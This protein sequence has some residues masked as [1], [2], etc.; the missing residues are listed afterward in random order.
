MWAVQYI[1]SPIHKFQK[2]LKPDF[3]PLPIRKSIHTR[4]A[5][6]DEL[7]QEG[8]LFGTQFP[9]LGIF[10]FKKVGFRKN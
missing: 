3:L 4:A 2:L 5:A 6:K 8:I 10:I 7:P 1:V 9:S